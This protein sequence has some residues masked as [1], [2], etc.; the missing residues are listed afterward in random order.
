M[1][2]Q[3]VTDHEWTDNG[4]SAKIHYTPINP[5][6]KDWLNINSGYLTSPE[7]PTLDCSWVITASMGS[8][9]SISFHIFEVKSLI[10]ILFFNYFYRTIYMFFLILFSTRLKVPL[11]ESIMVAVLWIAGIHTTHACLIIMIVLATIS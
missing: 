9:I 10:N 6:C 5:T 2:A 7:Y 3:F 11:L 8:T 1:L 4:F